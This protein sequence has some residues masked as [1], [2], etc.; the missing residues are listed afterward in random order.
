MNFPH[1]TGKENVWFVE[2]SKTARGTP[3]SGESA[4]SLSHTLEGL[5]ELTPRPSRTLDSPRALLPELQSIYDTHQ[6]CCARRRG[7]RTAS[8]TTDANSDCAF[9]ENALFYTDP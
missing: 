4:S 3:A 1:P 8:T 5:S 6:V 9:V 2:C 7:P